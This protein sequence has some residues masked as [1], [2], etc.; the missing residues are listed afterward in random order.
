MTCA[1]DG[2]CYRPADVPPDAAPRPDAGCTEDTCVG[3]TP[4]LCRDGVLVEKT[5]CENECKKGIC[6]AC[7][8]QATRCNANRPQQCDDNG[9]WVDQPACPTD[10]PRCELG[11]CMPACPTVGATRCSP[12]QQG[13]EACDN[14][15]LY[16]MTTLCTN[17]CAVTD[18]KA[19]C[20][21]VCRP[22]ARRCGPSQTPQHCGGDGQW[23][24]ETACAGICTGDGQCTGECHPGS[25][26]CAAGATNQVQTCT[27]DATWGAPSTCDFVCSATAQTCDGVC[28]PG[29][30]RC[31][32]SYVQ[33]CDA[34][35]TWQDDTLCGAVPCT[36]GE[37][38][39]C[40]DGTTQCNANVPQKCTGAAWVATQAQ[41]CPFL[42]DDARGCVGDCA[43]GTTTCDQQTLK[44][45]GKDG[46]YTSTQCP[47]ACLSSGQCGG[48]CVPGKHRCSAGTAQT[49]GV[50]GNWGAGESCAYGC[51]DT[52]GLC[53]PC[54][55]ET[56]DTTC[57]GGGCGPK[58]NNCGGDVVC[59]ACTGVGQT[60][61]GGGAAGVCGCPAES[62]DKTCAGRCSPTL[63]NC[64][65][66]V[67]CPNTC[68]SPQ[69]CGG[70]SQQ[71][72]C[73]CTAKT[74]AMACAGLNC[75]TV[76]DGCGSS[77]SCWPTGQTKCPGTAQTCGGGSAANVCGC[78]PTSDPCAGK[79]CGSLP[80][81]CG[82]MHACGMCG[83]GKM[84]DASGLCV[85]TCNPL[86][87][88]PAGD[89][90]GPLPAGCGAP[91]LNCGTCPASKPTC[92][93]NKCVCVPL[94]TCPAGACGNY[95][96]GCGGFLSCS[97]CSNNQI[98]GSNALCRDK[99]LNEAC[100][101]L[102]CG[103][104]TSGNSTYACN[105]MVSNPTACP[106]DKVC[107]SNV[108]VCAQVT[109]APSEDCGTK[110]NSCG[111][112]T[113][114]Q[115]NNCSGVGETCGGGGVANQCGCTSTTSDCV[116][117]CG[118]GTDN[119]GRDISCGKC[120][121]G[122]RCDAGFCEP[123]CHTC[124]CLCTCCGPNPC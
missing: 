69:T 99:T 15:G 109:C 4:Y 96:N 45:C 107:Q 60:C 25:T 106:T 35:G 124:T 119:C 87:S 118:L 85:D 72:V 54:V 30:K 95:P 48:T 68:K 105:G 38:K 104:V 117:D 9:S 52:S 31:A 43:P 83:A 103:N 16:R 123:I 66:S 2:K 63:N 26:R 14:T 39:P 5:P 97:G 94:A 33:K 89:D 93:N 64:G 74:P 88:C 90:C 86:T 13:I 102:S 50:D 112:S 73:G 70:G 42:C 1:S 98:C 34:N 3:K 67:D 91:D 24:D 21:G 92:S 80:D 44:V 59:P 6:L 111:N 81:S 65:T 61:G 37:C 120:P 8:P 115:P 17:V 23:V 11:V 10:Q 82:V 7:T 71:G 76:P 110:M 116:G 84:C 101:G 41:K 79:M 55:A 113:T 122:Y 62:M 28:T 12:E 57:A 22:D 114:C 78:T 56:L 32:G 47:F 19:V 29:A 121:A 58:K 53:K 46:T 51:D 77:V 100:A 40:T 36:F 27:A 108:C 75:G 49:C 18:G 20:G